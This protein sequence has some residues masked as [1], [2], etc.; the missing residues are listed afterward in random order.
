MAPTLF[1]C[2]KITRLSLEGGK[3]R[4]DDDIIVAKD[5][6]VTGSE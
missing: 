4:E 5:N 2:L 3:T 6:I 1:L